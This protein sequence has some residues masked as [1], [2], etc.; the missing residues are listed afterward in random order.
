L[1]ENCKIRLK[2]KTTTQEAPS[3]LA[4]YIDESG[5]LVIEPR[6]NRADGFSEG[7]AAAG[8]GENGDVMRYGFIDK[9]G[10]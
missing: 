1:S 8:V 2:T 6:F 7:L 10:A 3:G 9:T 4:G 5:A